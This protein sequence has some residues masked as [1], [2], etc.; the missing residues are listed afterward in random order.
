MNKPLM[1]FAGLIAAGGIAAGAYVIASSGGEEEVVGQVETVTPRA[2]AATVTPTPTLS[3]SAFPTASAAPS[4]TNPS[5][6]APDGYVTYTHL[7]SAA[8]PAFSLAYPPD[9]FLSGGSEPPEGAFGFGII[10]TPWDTKTAPGRGGIPLNS[11]KV[12]IGI[13]PIVLGG[14]GNCPPKDSEP[15]TLGGQAGWKMTSVIE[16]EP[17]EVIARVVAADRGD[18]RFCIIGYESEPPDPTIFDQI[19][20]SFQFL[21]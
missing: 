4:S 19:V 2:S 14:E 21:E 5:K 3:P 6:L 9:W 13:V 20:E 16:P 11:M 8:A 1:A 15:A 7:H 18:F 12:D 17:N 10:L